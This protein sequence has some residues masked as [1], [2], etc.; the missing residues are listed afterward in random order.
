CVVGDKHLAS[1]GRLELSVLYIVDIPHDLLDR[2]F[3]RR[4]VHKI[5]AL[6]LLKLEN[7]DGVTGFIISAENYPLVVCDQ[8]GSLAIAAKK[9]NVGREIAREIQPLVDYPKIVAR[10]RRLN[11]VAFSREDDV[12]HEPF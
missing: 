2:I 1:L 5:V 3:G 7:R 6:R 8:V 12:M 10:E 9:R 11:R 4:G